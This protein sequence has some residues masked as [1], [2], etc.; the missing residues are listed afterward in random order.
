MPEFER[1]TTWMDRTHD[2]RAAFV[3]EARRRFVGTE[4]A[5]FESKFES[6]FEWSRKSSDLCADEHFSLWMD[7]DDEVLGCWERADCDA[8]AGCIVAHIK[9][10]PVRSPPSAQ[11]SAR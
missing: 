3:R 7:D 8:F 9:L 11:G 2:C 6:K 10:P 4:L 5:A 1:C